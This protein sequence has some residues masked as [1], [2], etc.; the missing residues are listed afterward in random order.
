VDELGRILQARLKPGRLKHTQGV[1]KTA[2]KLAQIHGVSVPRARTAAWLHDCAKA[3]PKEELKAHLAASQADAQERAMPPLWHAPV[4]ALL[5]RREYGLRDAEVIKA[6]RF[7]STG[8]PGMSPLQ[9][10]LFVADYIE[11]NRPPWPELKS[12]RATA[13]RDLKA[14]FLDVLRYKL[15]DLLESR[16]PLHPRS[17]RAYHA[18]L[19]AAKDHA[20][21]GQGG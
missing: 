16:R 14:A 3:L 2:A 10:V 12:L 6:I 21:M 9:Q 19:S 18:A 17:I 4:G 11:P 1:V 5:A 7:H 8:A 13:R 15:M 20:A